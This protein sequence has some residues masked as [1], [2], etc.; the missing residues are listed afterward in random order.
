MNT[1]EFFGVFGYGIDYKQ[2]FT[3]ADARDDTNLSNDSLVNSSILNKL[4]DNSN[5][6]GVKNESRIV[7][8]SYAHDPAHDHSNC[9]HD[10]GHGHGHEYAQEV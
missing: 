3:I 5:S 10:H 9:N 6:V 8:S 1:L 7:R 4:H 2:V